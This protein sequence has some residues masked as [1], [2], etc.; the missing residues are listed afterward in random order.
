MDMVARLHAYFQAAD[1]L[2]TV[3]VLPITMDGPQH[4]LQHIANPK[5]DTLR[6]QI[7]ACVPAS[8]QPAPPL[9]GLDYVVLTQHSPLATIQEGLDTNARGFDPTAA[10]ATLPEAEA[11]RKGLVTNCAFTA[12]LNNQPVAAGM[13]TPPFHGIVEVVGVTTLSAYRR[14]G[15]GAALTSE[16]VQVAFSYGV[17][18]AILST[19]NPEAYRIYTRIGFAPVAWL[20][21]RP[22]V[23][24]ENT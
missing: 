4:D 10:A 11:F 12:R 13:F 8:F 14:R 16:I 9:V 6:T 22:E 20:L 23:Q 17:D 21:T 2:H 5:P 1:P 24:G 18:T 7:L 3:D 15:I 19:D